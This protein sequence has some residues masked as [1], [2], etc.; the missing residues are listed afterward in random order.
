[1]KIKEFVEG[2][3]SGKVDVV[4]HTKDALNEIGFIDNQFHF[5]N[6]IN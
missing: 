5:F 2:V 1:M 6:V 4:A 3:K